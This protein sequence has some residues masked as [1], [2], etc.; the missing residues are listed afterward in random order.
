M[1]V[2]EPNDIDPD[3]AQKAAA[4]SKGDTDMDAMQICGAHN[5]PLGPDGLCIQ[6]QRDYELSQMAQ[7][8]SGYQV[9][10]N[11]FAVLLVLGGCGAVGYFFIWPGYQRHLQQAAGVTDPEPEDSYAAVADDDDGPD[12][13]RRWGRPTFRKRTKKVAVR[14]PRTRVH[15]TK[16]ER[17]EIKNSLRAPYDKPKVKIIRPEIDNPRRSGVSAA[18]RRV[19]VVVYV[20][21]WCPACRK[22]RRWLRRKQIRHTVHNVERNRT[23]RMEL[24][25]INPRGSIP[26]F[27]IGRQVL[28][29]FSPSGV[30]RAIMRASR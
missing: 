12:P 25:S 13:Q 20:T 23:A 28:V 6:C 29:G 5:I 27:K 10:V 9:F 15:A 3:S 19:R 22:A 2:I 21:S 11:I 8:R 30:T 4:L 7:S 26:T 17:N 1:S 18:S 16:R 24:R 14:R